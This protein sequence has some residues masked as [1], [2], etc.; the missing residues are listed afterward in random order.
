M[1][2]TTY[3]NPGNRTTN[4]PRLIDRKRM[5]GGTAGYA[6]RLERQTITVGWE[7]S[8]TCDAGDPVPQTVLDICAGSGTTGVVALRNGRAFIGLD[9][10]REY[11]AMA[12]SRIAGDAPLLNTVEMAGA[13]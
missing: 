5:E 9:N 8:C 3:A 2:D 13:T 11:L 10:N 6:Q 1:T 12:A 4:G 7:P